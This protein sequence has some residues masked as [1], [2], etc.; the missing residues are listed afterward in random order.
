MYRWND[1]MSNQRLC[2]ESRP[3]T[4]LVH[5][6]QLQLCGHVA[7]LLAMYPTHRVVSVRDNPE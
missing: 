7:H 1:F 5:E 2:G 6:H 4:T 3:V